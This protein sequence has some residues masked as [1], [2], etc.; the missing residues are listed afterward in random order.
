M[1]NRLKI[2]LVGR[3]NVG[4]SALFN[5]I[6]KKRISIVDEAVGVTRDRLY[7]EADFFGRP[8]TLVDTGGIDPQAEIP[9]QDE[10]RLQTQIA[11]EEADVL[12]LVVDALVGVTTADEWVAHFLLRTQKKVLVAVN[13]VDDWGHLDKV[14]PFYSLGISD[15]VP[16]SAEQGF[17]IAELLEVALQGASPP[18]QETPSLPSIKVAI[19]GR[20]NV[21]KSTLVNF[22]LEEARCVVSP[23]AGTTRDSIDSVIEREGQRFTLIDTAGIRRKKSEQE[24]VEKFASVRTAKAM[25]RADICILVLDAQMGITAQEKRIAE[26]IE[27][28]GK[29]CLLL[30]NKWDLVKGFRMEHCLQGIQEEASFLRYCPTLFVSALT[31]RNLQELFTLLHRVHEQSLLRVS[32]GQLNKFVEQ[33]FQKYHPPMI[34]GKRLRVYYMTQVQSA[35]PRFVMFVNGPEL[36]LDSYKKYMENQ[37][38]LQYEF[39]GVPLVFEL[40][41]K[42][43]RSDQAPTVAAVASKEQVSEAPDLQE[44]LDSS[45]F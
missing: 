33:V 31:G 20:P 43:Q 22:L 26:Q 24:A 38:R 23:V 4:K 1:Q 8:F 25:A 11:V 12:I 6:C 45:Y 40:R 13:K 9:F 14:Y 16:V 3:P 27:S 10:V 44:E 32:T 21:G 7:A 37:F 15:V 39:L 34:R 35:P 29:C 30:L 36:M 18:C 42:G 17:Q 41:G 2:A 5:R 28:L 19:V